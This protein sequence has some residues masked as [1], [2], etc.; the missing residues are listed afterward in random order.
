MVATM[1]SFGGRLIVPGDAEY[2]DARHVWNLAI[3]CHPVVIARCSDTSDV[4]SALAMART[5]GMPIAVRGGGH[6]YPGHSTCDGGM[7]IDLRDLTD[8]SIDPRRR[9]ATAAPGLT[10]GA[11]TEA[12]S[13][14]GLAPVG[15]HVSS[16][17]IAGSTLG[18]G[19]GWLSRMHGLACDNLLE[20]EVVTAA[21]DIVTASAEQNPDLWWGL[22]GGGGNFGIV[23]RFTLRLHPVAPM[24]AGMLI[25]PGEQ[26]VSVLGAVGELG[27]A[28][29]DETSV[30]A[31]L[32][33]APPAPFIPPELVGQLVTMLVGCYVGPVQD[34]ERALA[35]LRKFGSPAVDTF[36]PT[37][38]AALQ[39]VFDA[40][41]AAPMPYYMR[42]HLLGRLDDAAAA[43]LVE[44]AAAVTSPLSSVLLVPMGGAIARVPSNATAVGHRDAAYCL[45]IGAA[46]LPPGEDSQPHRD[47]ADRIWQAMKPWSA[48]NEVN[49]QID[50]SPAGVL[51]AYGQQ[52]FARLAEVKRRWDPDN[53]FRLNH[54]IPPAGA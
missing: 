14:H 33:T 45:E 18:G 26:A 32:F 13:V 47:W 9:T 24:L 8:L 40:V 49:H 50:D 16:V 46:W 4:V 20:A 53:A 12:A 48:G 29:S 39:H 38:F 37:P 34:G 31:C 41:A 19:N 43:A 28:A 42:S 44:N 10:W 5:T 2:D 3:D 52:N 30:L 1:I 23:V 54:N 15:G 7:V 25:Y 36:A 11:L 51:A 27:A 22:R 6:S 35:P 17:G 21:G